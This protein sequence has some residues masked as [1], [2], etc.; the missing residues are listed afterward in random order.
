MP[1]PDMESLPDKL[2]RLRD[3][4]RDEVLKQYESIGPSGTFAIECVIKPAIARADEA[5]KTHD[6]VAMIKAVK[7][8]EEIK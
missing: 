3:Y 7:E 6:A 5:L 1:R 8:L 2:L 4:T